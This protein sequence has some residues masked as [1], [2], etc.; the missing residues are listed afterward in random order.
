MRSCNRD[1][2]IVLNAVELY[3]IVIVLYRNRI[4]GLVLV[5]SVM[6]QH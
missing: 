2:V 1:V 5:M 4:V 3:C 6:M